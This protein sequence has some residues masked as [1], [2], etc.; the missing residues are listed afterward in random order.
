MMKKPVLDAVLEALPA[1]V[2]L[3]LCFFLFM[4]LF[5]IPLGI[6]TAVKQNTWAD[7]IIRGVYFCGGICT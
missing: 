7:Y 5:A 2:I 6:Y 1:T 3:A 4:L